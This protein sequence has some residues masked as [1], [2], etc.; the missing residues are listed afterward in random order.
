MITWILNNE[1][2]LKLPPHYL[3]KYFR[4]CFIQMGNGISN[5]FLIRFSPGTVLGSSCL[6][7][8][9]FFNATF[10]KISAISWRPVLVVEETGVPG[11]N[12]RP[13]AS[14]W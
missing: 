6:V 8:W 3:I 7:Y 13:W 4:K 2:F 12:H 14:N 5:T 10:N 9:L 11:E 1:I